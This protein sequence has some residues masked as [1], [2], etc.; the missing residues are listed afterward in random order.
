MQLAVQS[1][2]ELTANIRL[3]EL[4]D[5]QGKKLPGY[6]AGAHIDI[7]VLIDSDQSGIRSYS[8]IDWSQPSDSPTCYCIAV[9]KEDD[10]DG[11]S[12]FMHTLT[13]GQSLVVSAPK[14]DFE[15]SDNP[16]PAVLIAGGIGVTPIISMAATLK[17]RSLPFHCHYTG[18]SRSVM[19]FADKMETQFG[20]SLSVYTDDESPID[21][22]A[23]INSAKSASHLYLCGPKGMI[24][25]ARSKAIDAGFP[26]EQIHIELFSTPEAKAEDQPF[27]VE[28]NSS[29]QVFVIPVGKTIIEVLEAEGVDVMF[30]CQRGD[31]GICQTDVISGTPDHRDLVLSD[32]ERNSGKV[33]Q[34][35]V[36]RAKTDRL[37]LDI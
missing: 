19:A 1:V 29:G 21:L 37:V 10:G 27:E 18:R 3:L 11:G 25:A 26:I 23:V 7:N 15:L 17:D 22:D 6:T 13:V 33:M 30:D 28:I 9:Q 31:C 24:E 35:C 5:E 36:S 12:A 20:Q 16:T 2:Q 32:D 14:N 34:I 4:V 8:L